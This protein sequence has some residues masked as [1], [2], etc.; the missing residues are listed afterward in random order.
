MFHVSP[1]QGKNKVTREQEYF[2]PWQL[3][4]LLAFSLTVYLCEAKCVSLLFEIDLFVA[5][6]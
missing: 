1:L 6:W 4:F 5:G 2:F 3:Y